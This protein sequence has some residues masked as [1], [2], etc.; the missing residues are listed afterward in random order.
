[1]KKKLSKIALVNTVVLLEPSTLSDVESW[2]GLEKGHQKT[3]QSQGKRNG[4]AKKVVDHNI[5]LK[6]SRC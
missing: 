3:E 6:L 2:C 5:G 4:E 1:M